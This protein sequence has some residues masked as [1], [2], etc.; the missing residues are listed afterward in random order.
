MQEEL[1]V[2]LILSE[3]LCAEKR[4]IDRNIE[5]DTVSRLQLSSSADPA[6]RASTNTSIS[7]Y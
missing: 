3:T 2:C 6:R 5:M 7:L 4:K 1:D